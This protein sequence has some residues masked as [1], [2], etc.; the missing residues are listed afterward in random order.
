MINSCVLKNNINGWKTSD[1]STVKGET[2]A[3]K[4]RMR[5]EQR[6]LGHRLCAAFVSVLLC[7]SFS[8]SISISR[9]SKRRVAPTESI[10]S[11]SVTGTR[12]MW[13]LL[14]HHKMGLPERSPTTHPL[15][16]IP[17]R[18]LLL[19]ISI[20]SALI[21]SPVYS[22]SDYT[23]LVYKGCADQNF[24]DPTGVY[25]QNL[26]SLLSTLVS[27]SSGKTYSSATAGKAEEAITGWFQCRG[28]LTN[29]QCGTCVSKIPE[30]SGRLCGKTIAARVQLTGCWLQYEVAGFKEVPDTELLY[31]VCGSTRASGAGFGERRDTALGMVESGV[32]G[33]GLFY[34]GSYQNVYVLGQC[35]GDLGSS[36]CVECV[37]AA[38]ERAQSE[39]GEAISGQVYLQKCYI[40]YSYYPSGVPSSTS[41]SSSP[42]PGKNTH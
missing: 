29:S 15:P 19:S 20:F 13:E 32:G 24:Q 12:C 30:L 2:N 39:C 21:V 4:L 16:L 3:E 5:A 6:Q 37:K 27:Q 31:K 36:E 40:S 7:F 14:H 11:R 33:D 17:L 10:P 8:F 34:T 22:S 25:S 18:T 23:N 35:E 9:S 28:D 41:S 1:Q 38:V 26:K 42:S